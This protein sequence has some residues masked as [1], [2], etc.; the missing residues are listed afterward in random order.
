MEVISFA[1]PFM[2]QSRQHV[3]SDDGNDGSTSN[4]APILAIQKSVQFLLI[5]KICA[6]SLASQKLLFAF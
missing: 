5:W 1:L 3:S 4:S 2:A 6:I